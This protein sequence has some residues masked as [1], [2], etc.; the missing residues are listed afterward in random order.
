M[1]FKRKK[2][3]WLVILVITA[4]LFTY[5]SYQ[6]R[7]RL[8]SNMPSE[9]VEAPPL[10]FPQQ[11]SAEEKLAR[12]YWDC[13]VKNIQ[14]R[15]GYGRAL[16]TDIPADFSLSVEPPAVAIEDQATRTRYWRKAQHLWALP[17][18]WTKEYEWDFNW[19]TDWLQT[20]GDWLHRAFQHLGGN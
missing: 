4:G 8:P 13:L 5:A 11:R 20:G 16:P 9:F 6:P 3:D 10:T 2:T 15:Y 19:T 17:N 12:S 7:F 1:L 14:W 18:L